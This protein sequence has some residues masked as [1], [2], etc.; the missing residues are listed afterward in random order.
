MKISIAFILVLSASPAWAEPTVITKLKSDELEKAG[1]PQAG[2]IVRCENG[3]AVYC[4]RPGSSM[5][6][7]C[8]DGAPVRAP[9]ETA[10]VQAGAT[11]PAVAAPH[12]RR[13]REPHH[14][15][16][17]YHRVRMRTLFDLLFRRH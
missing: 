17:H 1:C 15:V 5:H 4:E 3:T 14:Q 11:P 16:R 9:P 6:Y 12:A 10:P 7:S 2:F 13:E 8:I